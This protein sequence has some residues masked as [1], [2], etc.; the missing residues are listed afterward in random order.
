MRCRNDLLF[1]AASGQQT[2]GS[3]ACS[4]LLENGRKVIVQHERDVD[5]FCQLPVILKL[6]MLCLNLN[7]YT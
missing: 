7:L 6:N 1:K 5:K 2:V 3:C 4:A